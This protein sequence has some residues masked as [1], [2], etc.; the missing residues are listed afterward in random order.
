MAARQEE[1]IAGKD[2]DDLY[3]LLDNGFLDEDVDFEKDLAAL[4]IAESHEANFC[5]DECSKVCK[6]QR[7][8][9]RHKNT[10][11]SSSRSSSGVPVSSE[12][13]I[14]KKLQAD[15]LLRIV[16][17]CAE[18]CFNDLCLPQESRDIFSKKNFV[19]TSEDSLQLLQK[20]KYIVEDFSGD[21]EKFY[22]GFYGL[23]LDNLLP[24]KFED[25]TVTNILMT[26]AANHIL[27]HL[28]G[29]SDIVSL[30][31]PSKKSEHVLADRD[32]KSLQYIAGYIVHKM[33]TKFKFSNN[34][35]SDHSQQTLS[36]LKACKVEHDDSQTLVNLNDR[37]GLWKVNKEMQCI[38]IECENIFRARTSTFQTSIDSTSLVSEMLQ[39]CHVVSSYRLICYGV[40]PK[41][42]NEICFNI[43]EKMLML[44]TRVRTFSYAKDICEKYKS[45][46]KHTKKSSLRTE[47]KKA[48]SSTDM[49]H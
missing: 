31:P 36:I 3:A 37:G 27:I 42:P 30:Q 19:F 32:F 22:S 41:V 6:T 33:Y 43:L 23:L 7:G 47:I 13:I 10:K 21:G 38:F 28:S 9:T 17:E 11:H 35:K 40:E 44:F 48:S 25:E 2:L 49:G 14:E 26:E 16:N 34:Y 5:C 12:T 46:K 1:F 45:K 4:V 29:G 15:V 24:L 20:L 39:N 8:L 18:S